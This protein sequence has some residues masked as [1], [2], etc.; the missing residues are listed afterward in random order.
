VTK[1]WTRRQ[2][3]ELRA[4]LEYQRE[5]VDTWTPEPVVYFVQIAEQPESPIKIGSTTLNGLTDRMIGLQNG[6]PYRLRLLAL[7]DGDVRTEK[8]LHASFRDSRVIGE[9]FQPTAALL[10]MIEGLRAGKYRRLLT[11]GDDS[12]TRPHAGVVCE[13]LDPLTDNHQS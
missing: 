9:W 2:I 8:R 5:T 12:D 1:G 11:T 4:S 3:A 6:C 13:G 7:M 10:A